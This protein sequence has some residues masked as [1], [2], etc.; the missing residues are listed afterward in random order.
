MAQ[1]TA[2]LKI[3][4]IYDTSTAPDFAKTGAKY[5]VVFTNGLVLPLEDK[6]PK[7]ASE[8]HRAFLMHG[9]SGVRAPALIGPINLDAAKTFGKRIR[10]EGL[11]EPLRIYVRREMGFYAFTKPLMDIFAKR[12]RKK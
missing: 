5:I 6:P 12:Q 4:A 9:P 3:R 2:R 11:P 1:T 7:M 10:F 8:R